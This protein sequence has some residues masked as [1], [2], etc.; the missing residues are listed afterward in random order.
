[1][2]LGGEKLIDQHPK[3]NTCTIS[4]LNRLVISLLQNQSL[5]GAIYNTIQLFHVCRDHWIVAKK[6]PNS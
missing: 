4:K 1:M 3:I 2:I 6:A 5:I